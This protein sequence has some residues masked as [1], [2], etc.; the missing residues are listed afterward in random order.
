MRYTASLF[1]FL[2]M[3]TTACAAQDVT[4]GS[5]LDL[6][7]FFEGALTE[8]PVIGPCTLSDGTETT[9]YTLTIAGYPSNDDVGPFCP[10]TISSTAEEGGLWIDGETVYD[11]DGAFIVDLPTIYSDPNWKLYDDDGNV[12]IIDTA[13]DFAAAARPDVGPEYENYCVEG[14]IEWLEG[15]VPQT[16]TVQIPTN[17]VIAENAT[18]PS[19]DHANLGVTLNGVLI[20]GIANIDAILGAYTIAAFDDC[21]GHINPALGYHIHGAM[22]C[23]EHDHD[24][25][26]EEGETAIFGYALDGFPIH[27]PLSEEAKASANLDACQG[28]TTAELGYHYH[29]ADPADNEILTCFS[30][31]IVETQA[32]PDR[33]PRGG[34]AVASGRVDFAAAATAL[35]ITEDELRRA[36]GGPPPNFE[37]AASTLGISVEELQEALNR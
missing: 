19:Q 18:I 10:P 32:G 22:G 8:D 25:A 26:L 35:G 16:T 37:A 31:A 34:A 17:P 11:L 9:C 12:F 13:E 3:F 20:S 23:S 14:R 33:P 30:G 29:A 24:E 15:G 21:A 4:E 36:L 2:L 28:H 7:L 5:G 27:S 6:S 1:L